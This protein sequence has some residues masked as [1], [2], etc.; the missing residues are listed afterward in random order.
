MQSEQRTA[1]AVTRAAQLSL[2]VNV[3]VS[4]AQ[5]ACGILF[6]SR[7]LV[8]DGMHS[9]SDVLADLVVLFA[10]RHGRRQ[11][12]VG[13]PYG[14]QRFETA[15]SLLLGV[16]LA[17]VGAGLIVSALAALL[18]PAPA[19]PVDGAALAIVL[20][21]LAAKELLFRHLLATA[22]RT[23]SSLLEANAWHA[24]SDAASSLVVGIGVAGN[25]A[26]LPLLDPLAALVVGVMIV[27]T[28]SRFAWNALQ[29][30]VDRSLPEHE[31][32]QLRGTLLGTVG[33]L[34]VHELRARRMGDAVVADAH[35]EV[36]ASL[37]VACGHDIAV[38]AHERVM[39]DHP[40]A[41]L[42]LHVDPWQ[43]PDLDHTFPVP[44][45][46]CAR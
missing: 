7:A 3:L 15:A 39:A 43:Q 27:R 5:L 18:A 22:R 26:G 41:S 46:V 23:G 37:S 36:L 40:V 13:H 32:Q 45:V 29:D 20:A 21:V 35:I 33:V 8:A 6:H 14:H 16:M 30:L 34:G 24:R 12:D 42:V 11:P 44:H 10:S 25:L 17:V 31:L 28:G 9:L 2:A 4:G 1:H 38:A 19:A